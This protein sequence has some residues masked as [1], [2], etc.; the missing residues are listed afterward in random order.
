MGGN[1]MFIR[2]SSTKEAFT[3]E[4]EVMKTSEFG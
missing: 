2:F 4:L 3:V 1:K